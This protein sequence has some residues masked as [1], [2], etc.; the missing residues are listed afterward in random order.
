MKRLCKSPAR[1]KRTLVTQQLLP[2]LTYSC[3]LYP[4]G[5]EGGG[6]DQ[7][8]GSISRY[9][10]HGGGC[11]DAG[12]VDGV[13]ERRHRSVGQPR[14]YSEDTGTTVTGAPFLG[15]GAMR[16][17]DGGETKGADMGEGP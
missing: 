7:N 8:R 3:Q 11:G 2:I 16:E 6:S 5:R 9:A 4:D 1:G 10:S 17:T 14:D 13:R 12:S 15:R